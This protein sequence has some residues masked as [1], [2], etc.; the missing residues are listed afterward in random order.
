MEQAR[1]DETNLKGMPKYIVLTDNKTILKRRTK[2]AILVQTTEDEYADKLLYRAWKEEKEIEQLSNVKM[3]EKVDVF[4]KLVNTF[5]NKV[6]GENQ[7]MLVNQ[8][9]ESEED[10]DYDNFDDY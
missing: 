2:Q 6:V 8:S 9:C 5:G 4:P 3:A 7:E 10:I 1:T